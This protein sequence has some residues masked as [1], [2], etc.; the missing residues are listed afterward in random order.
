M[1][2]LIPPGATAMPEESINGENSEN[3]EAS[4][5]SSSQRTINPI[6]GAYEQPSLSSEPAMTDEE[7]EREA[8]KLF[9]LFDRMNR[10]GAMS[11]VNPVKEAQA[12]GKLMT[13]ADEE[14]MERRKLQ[15]EEEEDERQAL[16]EM[17][18]YKERK[19]KTAQ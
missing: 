4:S 13:T 15:E 19:N 9:V 1:N 16:A 2:M 5:S 6:T 8:E 7:K 3:S 12:A 18:R 11:V 10:N 17:Q 14:E